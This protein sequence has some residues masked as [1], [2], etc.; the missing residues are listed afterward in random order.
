[1]ATSL[2]F[3]NPPIKFESVK[4]EDATDMWVPMLDSLNNKR[5]RSG[6]FYSP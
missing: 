5:V 4:V 1:M 2:L 3:S 6:F